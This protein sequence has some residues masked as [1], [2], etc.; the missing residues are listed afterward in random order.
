MGLNYKTL[1]MKNGKCPR[2]DGCGYLDDGEHQPFKYWLEMPVQ[3]AV[4]LQAGIVKPYACPDC[5]GTGGEE[6]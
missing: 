4:A 5:M 1:V 2:C 6:E 3:S